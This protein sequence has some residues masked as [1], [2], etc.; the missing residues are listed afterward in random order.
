[1][2]IDKRR[3]PFSQTLLSLCSQPDAGDAPVYPPELLL[4]RVL[5]RLWAS[6]RVPSSSSSSFLQEMF[7]GQRHRSEEAGRG[8]PKGPPPSVLQLHLL[9]RG[10][11]G[12]GRPCCCCCWKAR[13]S[14]PSPTAPPA[15]PPLSPAWQEMLQIPGL[16]NHCSVATTRASVE[17]EAGGEEGRKAQLCSPGPPPRAPKQHYGEKP[18]L[19]IQGGPLACPREPPAMRGLEVEGLCWP[20]HPG[21]EIKDLSGSRFKEAPLPQRAGL[22]GSGFLGFLEPPAR[23]SA[24]LQGRPQ[25]PR[26]VGMSSWSLSV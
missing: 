5:L 24:G 23:G 15:S 12:Q 3:T 22:V 8:S 6:A 25:A 21:C 17:A 20:P 26:V 4:G 16:W 14:L 13:G 9:W 18:L 7:G 11:A 10:E 19:H 2:R 1:M